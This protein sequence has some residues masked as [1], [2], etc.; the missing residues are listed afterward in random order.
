MKEVW[1]VYSEQLFFAHHAF[2]LKIH[3]FVLMNN[4]FHLLATSPRANLSETMC[5]FMRETSR[6]LGRLSKRINQIYGRPY[7]GSSLTSNHY[8]LNAYKYV[9]RNPVE[10]GLAD[11]VESYPFSTL[12]ALL[13]AQH[14]MIPV[15]EDTL[16]FSDVESQLRWLNTPYPNAKMRES[17]RKALQRREFRFPRTTKGKPHPLETHLY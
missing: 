10:A 4:H 5:Y 8:F 17:I 16:L 7:F 3:S 11:C 13:G 2:G 9:Y 1:E 6:E 14:T 15:Q 12:R